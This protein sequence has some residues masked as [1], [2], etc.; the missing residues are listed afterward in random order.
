MR[1]TLVDLLERD[2][3]R[4]D[5]AGPGWLTI[6]ADAVLRQDMQ[7]VEDSLVVGIS[8]TQRRPEE[9]PEPATQQR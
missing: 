9:E 4:S 5:D 3:A 6:A 7:W 1:R 2:I 8:Q